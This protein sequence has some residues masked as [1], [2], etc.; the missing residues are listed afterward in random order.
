MGSYKGLGNTFKLNIK[1]GKLNLALSTVKQ[2]Y[3]LKIR[4]VSRRKPYIARGK[5]CR[6]LG[7]SLK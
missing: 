6:Y 3:K 5:G 7:K 1:K 4:P 2:I